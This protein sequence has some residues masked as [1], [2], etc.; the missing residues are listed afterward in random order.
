MPLPPMEEIKS[1]LHFVAV[2]GRSALGLDMT[3]WSVHTTRIFAAD[4]FSMVYFFLSF[5]IWVLT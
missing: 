4:V 3:G 5:F 1:F 2:N